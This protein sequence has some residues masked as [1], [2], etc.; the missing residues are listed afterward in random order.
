MVN[1][2]E[3]K[4]VED[5]IGLSTSIPN[6]T[7]RHSFRNFYMYCT[8]YGVDPL[9]FDDKDYIKVL[10]FYRSININKDHYNTTYPDMFKAYANN[11][12]DFIHTGTYHIANQKPWGLDNLKTS[13]PV[14][15]GPYTYIGVS[16]I[17]IS[18]ASKNKEL[19][20][21][22]AEI[23]MTKEV[24]SEKFLEMDLPA[25]D[26]TVDYSV[27][28]TE[29]AR[30]KKEWE[31]VVTKGK[32]LPKIKNQGKVEKVFKDNII[33]FIEGK[34]DGETVLRNLKNNVNNN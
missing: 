33:L 9:D 25:Y 22:V 26:I 7:E 3:I 30:M 24:I 27:L 5:L 10:D 19:A 14:A 8:L 15:P 20:K 34:I 2:Y 29:E 21:K 11:E 18:K 32:A 12:V 4:K 28:P 1:N 6:G 31:K 23:Y 13:H 16:G 17:G